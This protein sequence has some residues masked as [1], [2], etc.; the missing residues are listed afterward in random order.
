MFQN[1]PGSRAAAQ[2]RAALPASAPT[3]C[4]TGCVW[5][6]LPVA[7]AGSP[8]V[9]LPDVPWPRKRVVR[10]SICG[11]EPAAGLLHQQRPAELSARPCGGSTRTM[12]AAIAVLAM[13]ASAATALE[14]NIRMQPVVNSP[15]EDNVTQ[16]A[17]RAVLRPASATLKC[18]TPPAHLAAAAPAAFCAS[19]SPC[20]RAA[21]AL[22]SFLQGYI[23]VDDQFNSH[24][25]AWLSES[26]SQPSKDPL[27]VWLSG[28]PGCSSSLAM[29]TENGPC[30]AKE[31]GSG[32]T[33]NPFGWNT[34]ANLMYVDQPGET[35]TWLLVLVSPVGPRRPRS[36]AV[37]LRSRACDCRSPVPPPAPAPQPASGSATRTRAATPT[38]R[39]RWASSWSPSSPPSTP[40]T[41]STPATTS[42]WL[43][44]PTAATTAPR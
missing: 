38:T 14:A 4:A 15:C 8:P 35:T 11:D 43:A 1:V 17:V 36:A 3:A 26:R 21:R 41:P 23:D 13:A 37:R 27:I 28:G 2:P 22:L 39:P 33:H 30:T 20:C 9:I 42:T 19:G 12:L 40:S 16:Y 10:A 24:Y 44:S 31:D 18:R 29:M 7:T 25:F 5:V 34:Q 6:P 32:T